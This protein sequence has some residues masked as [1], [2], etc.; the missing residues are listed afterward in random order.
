MKATS[1]CK[2]K[3]INEK[4]IYLKKNY[5]KPRF[6]ILPWILDNSTVT[7]KRRERD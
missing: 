6:S 4:K 7:K 5:G 3:E 1:I 2:I